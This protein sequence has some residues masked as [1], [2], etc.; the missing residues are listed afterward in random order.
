[1][2]GAGTIDYSHWYVIVSEYHQI[3]GRKCKSEDYDA[4]K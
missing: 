2:L 1:M 4:G 3:K